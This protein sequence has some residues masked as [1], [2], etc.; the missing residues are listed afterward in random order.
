MG[1][2]FNI[3]VPDKAAMSASG[4]TVLSYTAPAGIS[5]YVKNLLLTPGAVSGS[6]A[7]FEARVRTGTLSGAGTST[8]DAVI[9]R[10]S[11]LSTSLG[12]GKCFYSSEP[13]FAAGVRE[14]K[15]MQLSPATVAGIPLGITLAPGETIS[16]HC[17]SPTTATI[18]PAFE[19][20][21][22]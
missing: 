19:A 2:S 5:V 12:T 6:D 9:A 21:I 8:I 17:I 18:I 3:T 14:S 20:E 22:A 16:L 7:K 4:T 13:T 1:T 11:G 10:A 15:R